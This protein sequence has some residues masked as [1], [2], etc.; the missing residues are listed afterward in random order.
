[1]L[2]SCLEYRKNIKK[3][4]TILLCCT[5]L[6]ALTACKGDS[7]ESK[8]K[9]DNNTPKKEFTAEGLLQAFMDAGMN[10]VNVEIYTPSTD[11]NELLGKPGQYI[12]KINFDDKDYIDESH[13]SA[14]AIEVFKYEKDMIERA[15]YIDSIKDILPIRYYM[16]QN[17]TILF[18]V[19]LDV[20]SEVAAAYEKIFNDYMRQ[21]TTAGTAS[22]VAGQKDVIQAAKDHL[23][24]MPFSRKELIEQLMLDGYAP[25]DAVHGADNCNAN[26]DEQ[27]AI[28]AKSY[29]KMISFTK[30]GL[31]DQLKFDGFTQ[32]QA[33]YG[34]NAAGL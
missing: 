26:W 22:S 25:A 16:Y 27:A 5:I 29:L 23:E 34:V 6:F 17:N 30:Q 1:M 14:F 20:P 10:I 28:M 13:T 19:P 33:E 3:I 31:I 24:I 32:Q 2:T 7:S 21:G 15:K 12:S 11:P 8:E 9:T 18:R 4:A